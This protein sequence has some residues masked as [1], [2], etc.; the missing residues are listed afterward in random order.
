[1]KIIY[2]KE[3][4][5]FGK[6]LNRIINTE[7]HYRDLSNL[8]LDLKKKEIALNNYNYKKKVLLNRLKLKLQLFQ[9]SKLQNLST[10][11]SSSGASTS[12]RIQI[13]DG[14]VKKTANIS[15]KAVN[16]CSPPDNKV[17]DCNLFPGGL[18]NNSS[19]AS[20]GSSESINSNFAFP[21]LN[22]FV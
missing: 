8:E 2:D 13:G 18:T 4:S 1:M 20:K 14:L 9:L 21:P 11:A 5:N 3:N 7:S 22:N 16:A 19:P 6:Y 15:D 12:S 17:I 10:F